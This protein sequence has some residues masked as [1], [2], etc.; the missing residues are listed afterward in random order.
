MD[1]QWARWLQKSLETYRVPAMLTRGRRIPQTIGRI[2]RD[3]DEL[4]ASA[5]LSKEIDAALQRSRFLIVNSG[6][7]AAHAAEPMD[8]PRSRAVSRIGPG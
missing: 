3:E 5:D 1:R 6:L 8:Q 2:F 4:A 7:L